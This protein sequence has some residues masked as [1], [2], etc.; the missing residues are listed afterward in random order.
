VLSHSRGG[1]IKSKNKGLPA[2]KKG[3]AIIIA[4]DSIK[5]GK[6]ITNIAELVKSQ[7]KI[8]QV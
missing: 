7:P 8:W 2:V 4:K 1:G 6:I 5:L 3:A